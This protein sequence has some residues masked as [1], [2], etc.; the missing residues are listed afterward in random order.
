MCRSLELGDLEWG[1]EC[2]GVVCLECGG[3]V[4]LEES[5]HLWGNVP[6]GGHSNFEKLCMEGVVAQRF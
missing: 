2:G 5:S 3:D 1:G 6:L 4:C